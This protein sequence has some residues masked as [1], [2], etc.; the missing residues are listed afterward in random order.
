MPQHWERTA[1]FAFGVMFLIALLAIAILIPNPTPTQYYVF[2]TILAASITGVLVL[3]PGTLE[4]KAYQELPSGNK[5]ALLGGGS[6]VIFLVVYLLTPS[7]V[8]APA[9]VRIRQ[10]TP[11]DVQFAY[12]AVYGPAPK[13]RTPP[14][15]GA[16]LGAVSPY[17]DMKSGKSLGAIFNENSA[18]VILPYYAK[19]K[20]PAY[21]VTSRIF[22]EFLSRFTAKPV[23]LVYLNIGPYPSRHE[24]RNFYDTF[25]LY[26]NAH[27]MAG[28]EKQKEV[29]SKSFAIFYRSAIGSDGERTIDHATL[30]FLFMPDGKPGWVVEDQDMEQVARSFLYYLANTAPQYI[31]LTLIAERLPRTASFLIPNAFA[32]ETSDLSRHLDAVRDKRTNEFVAHGGHLN[33]THAH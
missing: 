12:N 1:I 21:L 2:R 19:T 4:L 26:P 20:C 8:S 25:G 14:L 13:D 33:C 5:I 16:H 22:A 27:L 31:N 32:G 10:A 29:V 11:Q 17:Y 3:V 30:I 18:M 28:S 24:V 15:Q 6:I 9:E 23:E 7:F